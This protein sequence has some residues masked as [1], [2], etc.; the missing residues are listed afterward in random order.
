MLTCDYLKETK[1]LTVTL[2]KVK[3]ERTGLPPYYRYDV[4]DSDGEEVEFII[5][6][7]PNGSKV[8]IFYYNDNY[9]KAEFQIR[10][11]DEYFGHIEFHEYVDPN[12]KFMDAEISINEKDITEKYFSKFHPDLLRQK[13]SA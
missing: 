9:S 11:N 8:K 10:I 4:E 3:E 6:D 13:I 1:Q 5:E 12:L 2:N 7:E